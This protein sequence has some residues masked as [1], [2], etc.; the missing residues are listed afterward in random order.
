V[1]PDTW[2]PRVFGLKMVAPTP[3][4]TTAPPLRPS[5]LLLP[6]ECFR[7]TGN[8]DYYVG[9]LYRLCLD[10]KAMSRVDVSKKNCLNCSSVAIHF[11]VGFSL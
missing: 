3:N 1:Q 8:R 9:L 2:F 11:F 5:R 6:G 10:E 7:G 4:T